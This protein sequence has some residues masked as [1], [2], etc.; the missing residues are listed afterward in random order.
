MKGTYLKLST[1]NL[2]DIRKKTLKIS[3]TILLVQL[4]NPLTKVNR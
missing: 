2:V 1:A 3:S 4:T